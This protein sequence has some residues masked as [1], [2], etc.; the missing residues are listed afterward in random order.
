MNNK[1]SMDKSF[2]QMI[3]KRTICYAILG[4]QRAIENAGSSGEANAHKASQRALQ[5]LLQ[6]IEDER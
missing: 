4:T 2:P 5:E 3:D 6:A 1:V